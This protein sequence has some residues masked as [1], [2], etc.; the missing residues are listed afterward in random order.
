MNYLDF[1]IIVDN[2]NVT[3]RKH[4]VFSIPLVMP[5][6]G[7]A[8]TKDAGDLARTRLIKQGY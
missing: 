8:A 6:A 5:H 7:Y 2:T 3:R 1:S 4:P